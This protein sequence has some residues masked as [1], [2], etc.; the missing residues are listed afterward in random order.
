MNEIDKNECKFLKNCM[1][2]CF[3]IGFLVILFHIGII[4]IV[5]EFP[6]AIWI[7]SLIFW[8]GTFFVDGIL[9]LIELLKEVKVISQVGD[10]SGGGKTR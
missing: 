2:W 5:P 8:S 1:I 10:N 6:L 9:W 4:I 3:I 7:I